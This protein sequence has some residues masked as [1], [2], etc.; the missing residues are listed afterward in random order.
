MVLSKGTNEILRSWGISYDP[1]TKATLTSI[2]KEEFLN[3]L[4]S[5]QVDLDALNLVRTENA[6]NI[7]FTQDFLKSCFESQCCPFVVRFS[8]LSG[9]PVYYFSKFELT[10]S[11]IFSENILVEILSLFPEVRINKNKLMDQYYSHH[12]FSFLMSSLGWL[13]RAD[14]NIGPITTENIKLIEVASLSSV[15]DISL[16]PNSTILYSGYL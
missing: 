6:D 2:L 4:T 9:T 16:E 11:P 8:K 14:F 10:K 12:L 7:W 15:Q 3:K 13:E 1:N 5:Q